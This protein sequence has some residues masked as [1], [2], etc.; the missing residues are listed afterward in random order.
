MRK[1]I[2]KKFTWEEKTIALP[3]EK[4]LFDL[5]DLEGGG[6]IPELVY[7][8]DDNAS[9]LELGYFIITPEGFKQES[10]LKLKQPIQVLSGIKLSDHKDEDLLF[11]DSSNTLSIYEFDKVKRNLNLT[12]RKKIENLKNPLKIKTFTIG[13]TSYVLLISDNILLLKIDFEDEENLK[14]TQVFESS[15]Y[16]KDD[17]PSFYENGDFISVKDDGTIEILLCGEYSLCILEIKNGQFNL[18]CDPVSTES[19]IEEIY[20]YV[21]DK[22]AGFIHILCKTSEGTILFNYNG[23]E[24]RKKNLNIN[25]E[26]IDAITHHQSFDKKPTPIVIGD[27]SE[28]IGKISILNDLSSKTDPIDITNLEDISPDEGF[29]IVPLDILTHVYEPL[30]ISLIFAIFQNKASGFLDT[31]KPSIVIHPFYVQTNYELISESLLVEYIEKANRK[32]NDFYLYLLD[33]LDCFANYENEIEQEI[34]KLEEIVESIDLMEMVMQQKTLAKN[35]KKK[36]EDLNKKEDV[37]NIRLEIKHRVKKTKEKITKPIKITENS[38]GLEFSDFRLVNASDFTDSLIQNAPIKT[39]FNIINLSSVNICNFRFNRDQLSQIKEEKGIKIYLGPKAENEIDIIRSGKSYRFSLYLETSQIQNDNIIL[40]I[41][42]DFVTETGLVSKQAIITLP[43]FK[44]HTLLHVKTDI[45]PIEDDR[46][47]NL[48]LGL[49][50]DKRYSFHVKINPLI[51]TKIKNV[52]LRVDDKIKFGS[53]YF[54]Y[55]KNREI[56]ANQTEIIDFAEIVPKNIGKSKIGPLEIVTTEGTH[57]VPELIVHVKDKLPY[58]EIDSIKITD[59]NALIGEK[60][61]IGIPLYIRIELT[62]NDIGI[63]KIKPFIEPLTQNIKVESELE[64]F[65]IDQRETFVKDFLIRPIT[66]K[67]G[68]SGKLRIWFEYEDRKTSIDEFEIKIS[69]SPPE[70]NTK[71]ETKPEQ[72]LLTDLDKSGHIHVFTEVLEGYLKN[73]KFYFSYKDKDKIKVIPTHPLTLDYLNFK[74]KKVFDKNYEIKALKKASLESELTFVMEY[75]PY[76]DETIQK[77]AEFKKIELLKIPVWLDTVHKPKV[78]S[79]NIKEIIDKIESYLKMERKRFKK[80]IAESSMYLPFQLSQ[81]MLPTDLKDYSFMTVLSTMKKMNVDVVYNQQTQKHLI[82]E[83]IDNMIES[84][85]N[86][87]VNVFEYEIDNVKILPM[88]IL[89]R[90]FWDYLKRTVENLRKEIS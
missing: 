28:D 18:K 2:L 66:D 32:I 42:Y 14:V 54:E 73:P 64:P 26:L 47:F 23:K 70:F 76:F 87:G 78:I 22:S 41:S 63:S 71:I 52:K 69:L 45:Q 46:E 3:F 59:P 83:Q 33:G 24:F 51:D 79:I 81:T 49:E 8:Q 34:I 9:E 30:G 35:T 7:V 6:V 60:A 37:F 16:Y 57:I 80:C 56:F 90:C 65:S 84:M 39:S 53:N 36:L 17:L 21:P 11:I 19:F 40:P 67:Y 58:L 89:F 12:L 88:G 75:Q 43:R 68:E 29:K 48:S 31:Q 85:L 15:Q 62:K 10:L 72:L 50:K 4:A 5:V 77:S 20:S 86:A 38:R 1:T 13:D 74:E 55:L 61:P 82:M 44:C 27:L 25:P